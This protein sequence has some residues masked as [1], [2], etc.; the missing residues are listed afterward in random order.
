MINQFQGEY[1]WLSNFHYSLFKCDFKL[2][3]LPRKYVFPT[4]EHYYQATKAT[5]IGNFERVLEAETPGKAKRLGQRIIMIPNWEQWKERVMLEG[6]WAKFSQSPTLQQKLLATAGHDLMEGNYWN[7]KYWGVC[8]K[9][10]Q[11]QNK[12]GQILMHVRTILADHCF[13]TGRYYGT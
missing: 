1:Q 3:P 10:N 2:L 8:L 12:L 7:D 5:T 13:S 6:V 11:G 4:V 9:T